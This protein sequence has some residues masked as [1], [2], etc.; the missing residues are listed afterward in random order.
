MEHKIDEIIPY[1]FEGETI[2]LKVTPTKNNTCQGCFFYENCR[3]CWSDIKN[4]V[5]SCD[6]IHRSDNTPVIFTKINNNKIMKNITL[7]E[8]RELYKLGG[9]AK[10]IALRKIIPIGKY[11][12]TSKRMSNE[13]I[14]KD[15]KDIKRKRI[16]K[17]VN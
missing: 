5:G 16:V 12:N 1:N 8:A 7:E 10:E 6:K 14:N 3:T 17:Q 2:Y 4:I 15:V 9:I 13:P 11:V